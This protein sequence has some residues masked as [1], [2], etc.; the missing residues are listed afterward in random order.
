VSWQRLE[1]TTVAADLYEGQ[2]AR[3]AD[4]LWLYGRQWQVGELT[5]EDAASPILVEAR[6]EHAEITRFRPGPVT[7]RGGV[8]PSFARGR[9]LPLETAV[10]REPV[11]DGPAAARI[12]AEAGLQLWRLLEAAGAP[13]TLGPALRK[14]FPPVLPDDDGLDPVGRA[15]LVLLTRRNL[16]ADALYAAI[17][18]EDVDIGTALK[19]LPGLGQPSVR[20][21]FDAWRR[22]YGELYSEPPEGT[23]SWDA[24]GMEYAFQIA[25][26][27]GPQQEV[28]LEAPEYTGGRLDWYSFDVA[29]PG[30]TLGG[31][32]TL[33]AH[34][35]T[36][37]P[38]P[39]RY[40]GQAASRWWQVEN[41]NVWF[42]D[43]NTAPA[44]LA[45][46][47]VA[48]YGL[49]FG[50][51]W[52]L[53]PCR[54]PLGVLARGHHVHV[55]DT[56]GD[57]HT[58][59]S[60]A[61]NDGAGRTWRYF[62]L[63][64][65]HSADVLAITSG[66]TTP[67]KAT[68]CPWML[69][70]PTLAGRTESRPIEE[71]ALHRDE[72]ANLAWAAE[73]R[74]ESTSGRTIDR[75]ALARAAMAPATPAA[76]DAWRYRLTTQVP[77]HQVPLVPVR[78]DGGLYLQRGRLAVSGEDDVETTGALGEI[79]EPQHHLLIRDDAIP[80]TG[81]RVTRT[82]QMART[83]DGGYVLWVGRQ[84]RAGR[85]VRS[86]GLVFDEVVRET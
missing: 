6:I 25:A 2:E 30:V 18:G 61:E 40:A 4:P 52:L 35:L 34:D 46:V 86:P 51:D 62:E 41:A 53:V 58:I 76:D 73:L 69:L 22:W 78:K 21:A 37:V 19:G 12:A 16:G 39:V 36:V 75:A 10:E 43:M 44:D 1:S 67:S 56:Y 77:A 48:S 23:A 8:V 47:A 38:T 31:S 80:A 84:K 17:A 49:L 64:G 83:A 50:D 42:G 81:A 55:L 24:S 26:G 68:A 29:G 28:R 15:Q 79:L 13:A 59:R 45:R 54:L 72:I 85:P 60:C 3:I 7:T 70:P 9:G 32:G 5:G 57:R 71:I 27:V 20:D 11:H 14:R 82:W 63:T 74:I 66:P 33:E 65:D